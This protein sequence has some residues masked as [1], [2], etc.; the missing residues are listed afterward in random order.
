M[1]MFVWNNPDVARLEINSPASIADSY[2]FAPAGFGTPIPA[3]FSL[4]GLLALVN[5]GTA[6]PTHG[7]VPLQGF[8]A[9]H[10]AVVDRGSC[11]FGL[12]GVNAQNAGA[13]GMV[14]IN[15]VPGNATLSMGAG[16]VGNQVVI[17]AGMIGNDDGN[18]IRAELGG[19]VDGTI[20]GIAGDPN[21]DSD[22]DAG[23]IAHEYGHGISNRLT[24][25]PSTVSCLGNAE[26]MGEGWSDWVGL[27]LTTSPS[28]TA[29]TVRGIG[30]YLIFQP[31][32]GNGIRPTPYTT[33]MS[34]N[35]S[36]Y[37]S[38]ANAATISQPH[39]IGYVWNTMLWEMY[40]N[41]VDRHGYNANVYEGWD[42]A[43]NNLAIRL[44]NDG[45]KFQACRP[46][47]VDGRNAILAADVA[48]TGGE[49]Q[50]EIWRGFVKRGLGVNAMQGDSN[51][52]FDGVQNF[53][54]PAQCMAAQFGGFDRPVQAAPT[55]NHRD[56]G[57]VYPIKFTLSGDT[58][59]LSI[60]TQ[61][62]NCSTLEPTGEA[63]I[64]L[65][66][67][68]STGLTQ[69]GSKFHVNWQTDEAWAGSCRKVTLRVAAPSDPVA[70]FF[71]E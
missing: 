17:P 66:S 14:V 4:G 7:C 54:F 32:T 56:A 20:V 40:W 35:P 42:T 36:T 41:L 24:G 19:V 27:V 13:I 3:G 21:R 38:V 62:V 51:N 22:F 5:D 46:G 61:E 18:L 65:A 64:G 63:P 47:F 43:G 12:K 6:N 23:V 55:L 58:S 34:I 48:L 68:G 31:E 39:G 45:M 71:F 70:Y 15:N 25:G 8:P 50:C 16:A 53:D 26:Q 57:D 11:E 30:T 37:A 52:R 59:T 49:N 9:G 33:D 60:D 44:V 28:D 29:S 10:I 2:N 69:K 1:Q 67:P